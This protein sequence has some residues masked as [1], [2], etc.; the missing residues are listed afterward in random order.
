MPDMIPILTITLNP[1]V[2]IATMTAHVLPGPKLRCDEPRTDPGG[3]GIN[4]A[5]AIHQLGG[6]AR[7]FL[8]LGG[9]TGQRLAGL[10]AAK[11]IETLAFAVSGETRQSLTVTDQSNGGQYRFVLPGPFWTEAL[12][13]DALTKIGQDVAPGGIVVVSGSQPPGVDA[14][15]VAALSAILQG[16]G[17]RLI[18]D[19]SG[20]PLAHLVDHPCGVSVLRMDDGEAESV[21]GKPLPSR[22]ATADFAVGLVARGVAETV[23]VARGADGSTLV[24]ASER[25]HCARTVEK[26][27]SAVGAGDSF[28]GGFAMA[29]AQGAE[30]REALARGTAAASAAMLTEGTKL[31]ELDDAERL[32][33]TCKIFEL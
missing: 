26:V 2:D 13:R 3:G 29:L 27:K 16:R 28:V 24:T 8:A 15:F 18:V 4:V 1:T 32:Y 11:G 14:G 22:T 20:A 5:R 7:A 25:L 17:A 21:A 12:A 23:I 9:A 10:L 30:L 31:C 19:T 6:T 33:P